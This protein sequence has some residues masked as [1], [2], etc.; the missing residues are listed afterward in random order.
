MLRKPIFVL[1]GKH[2]ECCTLFAIK[3][4]TACLALYCDKL[5]LLIVANAEF[6]G[7]FMSTLRSYLIKLVS[8]SVHMSRPS[9]T[10]FYDFN[11]IWYVDRGQ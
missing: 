3:V 5:S 10:F 1:S 6:T 11:E 2:F 9:T 4:D 8:K 7:P